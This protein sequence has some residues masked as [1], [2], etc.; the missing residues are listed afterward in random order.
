MLLKLYPNLAFYI[1]CQA[2]DLK[3]KCFISIVFTIDA[4]SIDVHQIINGSHKK[5]ISVSF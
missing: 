2:S 1:G 3:R 5:C 4:K